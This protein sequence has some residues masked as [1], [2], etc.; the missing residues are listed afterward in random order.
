MPGLRFGCHY[1]IYPGDILRFHSHFL[2]TGL[3]W[4]EEFD[5]LDIIGGGR[6]ANRNK[7][8]YLIGGEM[9]DLE[10][11]TDGEGS[12]SSTDSV[13]VFSIEWAAQG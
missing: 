3:G 6:L 2:G 9:P 11:V 8:A 12:S 7:K 4:D 5:L 10:T 1:S 13:R